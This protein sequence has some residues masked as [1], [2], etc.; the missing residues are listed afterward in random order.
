[1]L[2]PHISLSL[3]SCHIGG[4]LGKEEKYLLSHYDCLRQTQESETLGTVCLQTSARDVVMETFTI[5]G[6]FTILDP[7]SDTKHATFRL[8]YRQPKTVVAIRE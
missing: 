7:T 2:A 4:T 1:M 3:S 6:D 5:L 8:S